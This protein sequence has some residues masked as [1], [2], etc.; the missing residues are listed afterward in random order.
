[1][2]TADLNWTLASMAWSVAGLIIG[3]ALG[4]MSRDVHELREALVDEQDA[5]D[6]AVG[7]ERRSGED[8]RAP[9]Q[10]NRTSQLLGVAIIILAA[11]SVSASAVAVQRQS[12]QV[13]CQNRYN[14]S[15]ADALSERSRAADAD[16]AAITRLITVS[17]QLNTEAQAL[18]PSDP[19]DAAAYQALQKR[20]TQATK[21]YL[22]ALGEADK[23]RAANP[24]PAPPGDLCG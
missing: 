17:A 18:D 22:D 8:R 4:R 19:K 6:D 23:R 16:R 2:R 11:L 3:Y 20:A 13:A 21:D 9:V 12:D 24:I 7:R 15:F 14:R 5:H 10:P 1:M